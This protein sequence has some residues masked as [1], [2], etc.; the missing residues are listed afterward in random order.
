MKSDFLLAITQ[1]SAEKNLSKEVVLAA[2]EAALVSAYRKE[3]FAPNQN[4]QVKIDPATGRVKVWAEKTVVEKVDDPRKEITLAEAKRIQPGIQLGEPVAVESTPA[5][6]GRIAAQTAKQVILQRLHEAENT[7]IVDEYAGKAGDIVSGVIQRIE[8]KQIIVDLGRA[9]AVMPLQ[10]QVHTERYRPGQRIRAYL[11]EVAKGIKGP[12]VVL[13]RSHPGLLR[14]LFE[15]EIPEIF[16]GMVEIKSVA[17]EAG[18]RSKVAVAAR[19]TG[20]DPVGCCVGL[21]GIRIQNIVS[22][23]SGEKIDVVSWSPDP[24]VFI[25]NALSPAQVVRVILSES[26]KS[27]TAVIPDRQQSLA[28]GKEGQNVR[29]AVKLTGWRIDIKSVS[30]YEAAHPVV[31]PEAVSKAPEAV[32]QPVIEK[33]LEK[34]AEKVAEKVAEKAPVRH[35]EKPEKPVEVAPAVPVVEPVIP[36]PVAV[37]APAMQAPVEEEVG[38]KLSLNVPERVPVGAGSKSGVRFAEDILGRSGDRGVDKKKKKGKDDEG[39][40]GKKKRSGGAGEFDT[41]EYD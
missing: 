11:V 22:E 19:Q 39:G 17:R 7:A 13:S 14:R 37:T 27:A 1:L 38:L 10:E 30:D 3:S 29:L 35:V 20:I 40:R 34:P 6:A 25:A 12:T 33:T 24:A 8:P 9:E 28:I 26:D 16:S 18:A 41:D 31:T 32:A 4:I 15:M 36:E 2:V 5:D 23:L 21:R